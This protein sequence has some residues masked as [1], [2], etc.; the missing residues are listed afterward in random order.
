KVALSLHSL[1]ETDA[2]EEEKKRVCHSL[3]E[4]TDHI[5]REVEEALDKLRGARFSENETSLREERSHL[6]QRYQTLKEKLRKVRGIISRQAGEEVMVVTPLQQ[7]N[8]KIGYCYFCDVSIS[9][10]FAYKL[11]EREQSTLGIELAEGTAFCSQ[12]QV[13]KPENAGFFRRLGQKLGLVK[14]PNPLSKIERVRRL[15]E[16]L[17]IQLKSEG[18]ELKKALLFLS[19]S[20]QKEEE[21]KRLEEKFLSKKNKIEPIELPN[22]PVENIL[23]AEY[24]V[25]PGQ[26]LKTPCFVELIFASKFMRDCYRVGGKVLGKKLNLEILTNQ[27]AMV[28][29]AL[30][31]YIR[32]ENCY[33][34]WTSKEQFFNRTMPKNETTSEKAENHFFSQFYVAK[35]G[36][37]RLY[38]AYEAASEKENRK[39][40]NL[41]LENPLHCQAYLEI[42][43]E[44]GY[45][46]QTEKEQRANYPKYYEVKIKGDAEQEKIKELEE[47]KDRPKPK[48]EREREMI[49][50]A[51]AEETLMSLELYIQKLD[52]YPG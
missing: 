20:K 49:L 45:A 42:N 8:V 50:E 38:S 19:L 35:N 37:N 1:T 14:K 13:E 2:S 9:D 26:F 28:L 7:K 51:F 24:V 40:I 12:N 11:N 3:L 27:L 34:D 44:F 10:N 43:K 15:K 23:V 31:E 48:D 47:K 4:R 16:K 36:N 39:I 30:E 22:I 17:N 21:R 25:A 46:P 41:D 6:I 18:E 32:K 33:S 29:E 52:Y 5:I